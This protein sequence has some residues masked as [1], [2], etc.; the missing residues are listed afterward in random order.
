MEHSQN[1]NLWNKQTQQQLASYI[2]PTK[3]E[4]TI[5]IITPNSSPRQIATLERNITYKEP[6]IN[7]CNRTT[8]MK[9]KSEW[10]V[11]PVFVDIVKLALKTREDC[12]TRQV[13]MNSIFDDL[14]I[15]IF[16]DK[17]SFNFYHRIKFPSFNFN[18]VTH[19]DYQMAQ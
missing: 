14:L 17:F 13:T 16:L 10:V 7:N 18:D 15:N 6:S 9:T 8:I 12:S 1:L 3:R 11:Q 19:S 4:K 2:E 5:Q